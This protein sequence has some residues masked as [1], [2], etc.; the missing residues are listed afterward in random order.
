MLG[1][2]TTVHRPQTT[3][4]RPL[5]RFVKLTWLSLDFTPA[6]V[7]FNPGCFACKLLI[8]NKPLGLVKKGQNFL[9]FGLLSAGPAGVWEH[10]HVFDNWAFVQNPLT[11]FLLFLVRSLVLE[12][13]HWRR[14]RRRRLQAI[15]ALQTGDSGR[16]T[17]CWW[18]VCWR[19]LER[20]LRATALL[21]RE[22]VMWWC[23]AVCSGGLS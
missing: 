11:S 4:T 14:A 18:R 1:R 19:W 8:L 22:V 23:C 15:A 2:H 17:A 10:G 7:D 3:D 6:I 16:E 21:L 12:E 13:K 9:A 5:L 20:A